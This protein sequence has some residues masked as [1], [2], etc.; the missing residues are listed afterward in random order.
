M[1]NV[2]ALAGDRDQI[3][4]EAVMRFRAGA[5]WWL[6]TPALEAL[7]AAEQ[8]ARF[9]TDVWKEPIEDWLG[10]RKDTSIEEVLWHALGFAPREQ[11]HSAEIR[12]ANILT[13]LSFTKHR[14]RKGGK[15]TNRYWRE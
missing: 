11:N 9:K 4:A 13:N 7:A 6:D 3:W 15:R 5:K 12:V 1:I 2:E 14:P 8:A 10:D